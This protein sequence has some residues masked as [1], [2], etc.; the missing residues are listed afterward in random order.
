MSAVARLAKLKLRQHMPKDTYQAV[1]MRPFHA[2]ISIFLLA[3]HK[4]GRT[5]LESFAKAMRCN[6]VKLFDLAHRD[7][8]R[9]RARYLALVPLR[10]ASRA[11][12]DA[13]CLAV[14]DKRRDALADDVADE[15]V[16]MFAVDEVVYQLIESMIDEAG[17]PGGWMDRIMGPLP[18]PGLCRVRPLKPV[19]MPDAA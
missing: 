2:R 9:F 14:E 17:G 15:I 10:P 1:D 4:P 6:V 8:K 5:T 3:H 18:W 13:K 11:A 12:W 7:R 19:E 16:R